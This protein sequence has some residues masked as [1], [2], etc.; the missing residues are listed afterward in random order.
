MFTKTEETILDALPPKYKYIRRSQGGLII[1]EKSEFA[2]NE[3]YYMP[4][5][6]HIFKDVKAGAKPIRF[7]KEI[8]DETELAYLKAVLRPFARRIEHVAKI[9]CEGMWVGMEYIKVLM[10]DH[11]GDSMCFPIFKAGTMYKGMKPNAT[12]T[13]EELGITYD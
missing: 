6:N 10:E 1:I 2:L 9:R 11:A 4:M 8:L 12:Y 13:L 3:T 5:F 7:R